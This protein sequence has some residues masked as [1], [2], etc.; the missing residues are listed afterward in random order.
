MTLAATVALGFIV[1]VAQ[2]IYAA[3]L[4]VSLP[5]GAIGYIK[6]SISPL[7]VRREDPPMSVPPHHLP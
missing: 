2:G 6:A 4:M 7:V 3:V 5:I 1:L